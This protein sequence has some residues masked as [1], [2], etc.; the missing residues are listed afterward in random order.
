VISVYCYAILG[1]E[2][3][4]ASKYLSA[5]ELFSS[6][7]KLR[8]EGVWVRQFH[9]RPG[10]ASPFVFLSWLAARTTRLRLGTGVVTLPLEN[11]VRVAEDAAVLDALS[12][13]RLELGVA[14]GG[15]APALAEVFRG[16]P[17]ADRKAAY[18]DGLAQ[19]TAA[20]EGQPVG[21]GFLNPPAP[22]LSGRI[23][24]ATLSEQSGYEKGL[25]AA[26]VL[27][28]GEG[29][30]DQPA[31]RDPV[32]DHGVDPRP[33][34]LPLRDAAHGAN[35]AVLPQLHAPRGSPG[36]VRPRR[37]PRPRLT[38]PRTASHRVPIGVALD[39]S[40]V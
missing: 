10:L 1:E 2:G 19:L 38:P 22:G 39:P 26:R 33:A 16:G 4:Q 24:E 40:G 7:E 28:G 35:R 14:N 27:P 32:P 30:G 25:P 6:A 13:G 34:G 15:G 12:G 29:S 20:L 18:L 8:V 31:L 37:P 17:L 11:P 23:W 3:D 5:L 21:G 36:T 9:L